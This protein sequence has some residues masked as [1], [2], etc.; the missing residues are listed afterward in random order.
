MGRVPVGSLE[1][2]RGVPL[3]ELGM[4]GCGSV[5]SLEPLKGCPLKKLSVR[6]TRFATAAV[7]AEIKKMIPSIK[8][9]CRD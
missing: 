5:R 7:E 1:P 4:D 8:E 2:L 6:G 3:E 9:F